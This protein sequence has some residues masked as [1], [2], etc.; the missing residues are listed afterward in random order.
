MAKLSKR[1]AKAFITDRP[2]PHDSLRQA[3]DILRFHTQIFAY[4]RDPVQF[5]T[6]STI[7]KSVTAQKKIQE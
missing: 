4:W 6:I 1:P 3:Q 2:R 5:L 7:A